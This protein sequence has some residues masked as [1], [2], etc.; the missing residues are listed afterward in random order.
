M[1]ATILGKLTFNAR[2]ERWECDTNNH[3]NTRFYTRS[4]QSAAEVATAAAS[5]KSAGLAT[6]NARHIRFHKELLVAAPVQVRSGIL[7]GGPYDGVVLH[8]LSSEGHLS[9]TALDWS[10]TLAADLP[11][12]PS[13]AVSMSFPRGIDA[14]KPI[15]LTNPQDRVEVELGPVRSFDVDH[16]GNLLF[17]SMIRMTTVGAHKLMVAIGFTPAFV[18]A[19]RISRMVAEL[20]LELHRKC[21]S[22]DLLRVHSSLT[23]TSGKT[24]NVV[25]ELL[26]RTGQ[27]VASIEQC[28][29]TVDL[30]KRRA[31]ELPDFVRA[32]RLD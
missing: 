24:F 32:L 5:G 26:T 10:E 25:N 29:V 21:T 27:P 19:T 4:F 8:L 28:L 3:W 13:S 2:V 7:T 17:E 1:D 18:E 23:S 12:I 15:A 20:R 11:E 9:A 6:L 31:V 22:G 14:S 16:M 30:R